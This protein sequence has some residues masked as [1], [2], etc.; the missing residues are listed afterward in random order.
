M[1]VENVRV[2]GVRSRRVHTKNRDL[3]QTEIASYPQMLRVVAGVSEVRIRRIHHV[4]R[5][6]TQTEKTIA[7]H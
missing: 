7:C 4:N 5:D 1:A 2:T 6:L 3:K